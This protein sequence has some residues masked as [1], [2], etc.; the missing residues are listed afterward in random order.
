M[1]H[2]LAL[3]MKY[4]NNLQ[5]LNVLM[6]SNMKFGIYICPVL[7]RK[8]KPLIRNS[9]IFSS[10]HLCSCASWVVAIVFYLGVLQLYKRQTD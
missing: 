10:K 8:Q 6:S 5:S 1:L 7:E 2:K 3:F 4:A 9:P